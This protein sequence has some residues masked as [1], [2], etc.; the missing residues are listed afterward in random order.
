MYL[1]NVSEKAVAILNTVV[2][3]VAIKPGE[4]IKLQYKI[5][6]PVPSC[7]GKVTE[8]EFLSYIEQKEG[9]LSTII[10]QQ[11]DKEAE[12]KEVESNENFEQLEKTNENGIKDNSVMDFVTSL[13]KKHDEQKS[14]DNQ[15]E[16]LDKKDEALLQKDALEVQITNSASEAE[17][18][19]QQIEDLQQSWKSTKSPRKKERIAKE[20]KELEKRLKKVHE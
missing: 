1:K 19:E 16:S 2:G 7:L 5:L 17:K 8:E 18:I 6:P 3:K 20:L 9:A 4:V 13:F 14:E 11:E 12:L 15:S 10:K